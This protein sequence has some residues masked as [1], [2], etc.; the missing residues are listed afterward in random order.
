VRTIGRGV[1]IL[2]VALATAGTQPYGRPAEAEAAWPSLVLGPEAAR[3]ADPV[4]IAHAGDG[5]GR[6]FVGERRGRII[7]FGG[8]N[9]EQAPFLDI[10]DRVSAR[11]GGLRGIAFPYDFVDKRY[12]CVSYV[13]AGR[14]LRI[15]RYRLGAGG[16]KAEPGSEE[17]LLRIVLP[18]GER[19]G[20]GIA[21]GLDGKLYVGVGEG[22]A[23]RKSRGEAQDRGSLAG[24]I[25]R[26]EGDPAASRYG[27]PSDNPFAKIPGARPEIWAT[28]LGNPSWVGFDPKR[29]DLYIADS[30]GDHRD[31]IN[32]QPGT[33]GGGE[34]YGWNILEGP[35]CRLKKPCETAG[36]T[37][38]ATA[39][40]RPAMCEVTAGVVPGEGAR[41]ESVD[42]FIYGDR[43]SGR[44][45]G[46]R[47]SE[48]G[49]WETRALRDTGLTIGALGAGEGGEI[50]IADGSTGRIRRVVPA[51]A[52][53]TP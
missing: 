5:S 1:L 2:T 44:L 27:V 26:I 52:A 16:A 39:P 28:G 3:A 18:G 22:V 53:G 48:A 15:A 7:V 23:A 21:F 24:K 43:C 33:S 29:G 14:E 36:F 41:P 9:R 17:I 31:E 42:V 13:G 46:L 19:P 51:P 6:V 30:R 40:A 11:D 20:G 35:D 37:P 38:P 32:F 34:N 8:E 50:Y 12:F 49:D 10:G 47:R 4:F 45:W 25:L